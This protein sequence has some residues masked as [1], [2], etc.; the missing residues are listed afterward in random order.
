MAGFAQKCA[1]LL[2]IKWIHNL[3]DI[4]IALTVLQTLDWLRIA[5]NYFGL[6]GLRHAN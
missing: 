1:K 4:S 5:Y 3:S 6:N 2:S